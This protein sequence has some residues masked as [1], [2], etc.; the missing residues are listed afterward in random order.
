MKRIGVVFAT[1][2]HAPGGAGM[3]KF[4]MTPLSTSRGKPTRL[5]Q[6]TNQI[7]D[8]SWHGDDM[9]KPCAEIKL[10]KTCA[11]SFMLNVNRNDLPG[12]DLST[13]SR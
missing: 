10:Q 11:V 6:V 2:N 9:I 8:F 5:L 12:A 7:A 3:G 13:S 1:K 4:P